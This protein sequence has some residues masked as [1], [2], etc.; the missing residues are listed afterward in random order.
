MKYW[1]YL[2]PANKCFSFTTP[3][4]GVYRHHEQIPFE[5]SGYG[6]KIFFAIRGPKQDGHAFIGAA[7]RRGASVIIGENI[8]FPTKTSNLRPK[9]APEAKLPSEDTWLEPSHPPLKINVPDSAI[10][11]AEVQRRWYGSPD[12]SLRIFGVTGTAGKTTVTHA[13]Q[14]LLGE[15]CGRMGT[16]DIAWKNWCSSSPQ[17]TLDASLTFSFLQRMA[18]AGCRSVAIEVSSHG[19]MQRRLWG[20][21][22]ECAIFTNLSQDHLDFHGTMDAYFDAKLRLFDGRNGS[23]P[24][25]AVINGDDPYGQQLTAILRKRGQSYATVGTDPNAHWQLLNCKRT[26]SGMQ[27]H[28]RH[29][30]HCYSFSTTLIGDFNGLN[31]LQAL[32]AVAEKIP[33]ASDEGAVLLER[34]SSFTPVKGRMQRLV[35]GAGEVF[36]DFS[37][38]PAALE[39]TLITLRERSQGPLWTL[40]GCGGNRDRGKRP[41]MAAIAERYSD[42]VVVTDDNPRDE[43][44]E[45]ITDEITRGFSK[46][47]FR[48]IHDRKEAI[49]WAVESLLAHRGTLLL[50]GKGH[51][52]AQLIRRQVIPFNDVSVAQECIKACNDKDFQ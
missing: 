35:A 44:P 31:L 23:I 52:N 33:L 48:V 6:L 4:E 15:N 5:K 19:I 38:S 11:W 9:S 3:V 17:T 14:H 13:I 12:R 49:R 40:F 50:A 28:F 22:F 30:N 43:P 27:V 37:H 25:H 16:V 34:I 51:E 41:Q 36:I 39:Q 45:N 32:A 20:L 1:G 47:N 21:P 18:I 24:R 26:A 42:F 29:K 7:I 46:N 2:F 10:A 8:K